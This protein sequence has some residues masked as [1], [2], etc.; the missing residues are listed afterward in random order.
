MQYV[1][2]ASYPTYTHTLWKKLGDYG[3]HDN[4]ILFTD[5]IETRYMVT[6]NELGPFA[7]DI[8]LATYLNTI[9]SHFTL[10]NLHSGP[11]EHEY[12]SSFSTLAYRELPSDSPTETLQIAQ[13]MLTI[14]KLVDEFVSHD[15]KQESFVVP[16]EWLSPKLRILVKELCAR[17]H[18]SFQG[19]IFVE[20]RQIAVTLAWILSKISELKSWIFPGA[21]VGHGTARLSSTQ[22]MVDK[23]QKQTINSFRTG[24]YNLLVSTSVG[25]EGLDFQVRV[26]SSQLVIVFAYFLILGL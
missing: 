25:E 1:A 22:G 6:L 26:T 18:N 14:K 7:A 12:M 3:L 20:Q 24:V 11:M 9:L 5:K 10:S 16:N 17:R 13:D 21:I 2:T 19:M 8:Y 23:K 15:F 4:P